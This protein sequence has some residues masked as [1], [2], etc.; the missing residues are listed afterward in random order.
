MTLSDH[1]KALEYYKSHQEELVKM[2]NGK[3][4]IFHSDEILSVKDSLEEAYNFALK[5]Y[6]I[7]NFSLQEVG[8]TAS[9][10]TAYIAS[11]GV[12]V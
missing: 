4:I 9:S 8:P 1:N 11:P 10:Y 6:G 5:E 7:G 3:T 2:Y 12:I